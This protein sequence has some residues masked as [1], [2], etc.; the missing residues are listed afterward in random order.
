MSH[1]LLKSHK[2]LQKT[3]FANKNKK[4]Q[5][6]TLNNNLKIAKQTMVY[7]IVYFNG[8]GRAEVL[9]LIAEAGSV[10]Y[11]FKG[12]TKEDWPQHKPNARYGQL[13]FLKVNENFTLYQTLVIARFLAQEGN[14]YPTDRLQAAESE[15]YVTSL[16]EL[17]IKYY[18]VY[19][20][21][22]EKRQEELHSFIE[23]PLK[24]VFSVLNEALEKNVGYLIDGKLSWAD[25]FLYDLTAMF[26]ERGVDFISA[27]PNINKLR[28]NIKN[29]LAL[30]AYLESDRNLRKK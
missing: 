25:L 21:P 4:K 17:F 24:T 30:K 19:F 2:A 20:A 15:E 23:G 27:I 14:L 3:D 11:T 1:F 9:K 26:E 13:P 5:T 8:P 16:E 29:N 7:E 22:E 12:I 18:K 10:P 6:S 28:E